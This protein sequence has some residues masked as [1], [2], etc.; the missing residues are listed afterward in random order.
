LV[1]IEHLL[2]LFGIFLKPLLLGEIREELFL[3]KKGFGLF[4]SFG[5]G[6][7]YIWVLTLK[8]FFWGRRN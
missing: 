2:K 1:W 6:N 5:K 3:I 4:P 8:P 7:Y